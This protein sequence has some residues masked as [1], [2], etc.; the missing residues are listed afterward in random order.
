MAGSLMIS[1]DRHCDEATAVVFLVRAKL[2]SE[3]MDAVPN[4][5]CCLCDFAESPCVLQGVA[6]ARAVMVLLSSGTLTS[7]QQLAIAACAVKARADFGSPDVIP[8]SIPGFV[9]P[10]E[11]FF[12]T[13]LPDMFRSPQQRGFTLATAHANAAA[14]DQTPM[15]V[16]FAF[17]E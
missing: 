6:S 17:A 10:I 15:G 3:L 11:E 4:G 2:E 1:S 12:A 14:S 13:S 5:L 9:F 16:D 7:P 8:V